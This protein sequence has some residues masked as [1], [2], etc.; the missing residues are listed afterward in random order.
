MEIIARI[1]SPSAVVGG[2]F[3]VSGDQVFTAAHV[4][5]A[6]L[7]RPLASAA[8]PEGTI[9]VDFPFAPSAP[10]VTC[11]VVRWTPPS[12]SDIATLRIDK[13]LDFGA[14]QK[15]LADAT[16][17]STAT[18]RSYGF[19]NGYDAGVWAYGELQDRVANG[20][21]QLQ[22]HPEGWMSDHARVQR[23][24]RVSTAGPLRAYTAAPSSAWWH[25]RTRATA[26]PSSFPASKL[27]KQLD[28]E[29]PRRGTFGWK[30][31]FF[32]SSTMT[33]LLSD[34]ST[35]EDEGI[36]EVEC[37]QIKMALENTANVFSDLDGAA[38]WEEPLHKDV[39]LIRNIYDKWNGC[40]SG[41][42]GG[43]ETQGDAD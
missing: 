4:I 20:L 35:Y 43:G 33:A 37:R 3:L 9:V 1:H 22:C 25:G 15:L 7:D 11:E 39:E 23:L 18:I 10:K 40:Q 2:G 14:K 17:R 36:E 32:R 5:N 30:I 6:A 16:L 31:D 26:W 13:A 29:Q 34:L 24:S 8:E 28:G 42:T 12:K 38:F 27:V 21:W 19:P 41:K